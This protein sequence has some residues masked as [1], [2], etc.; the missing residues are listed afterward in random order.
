MNGPAEMP[1]VPTHLEAVQV[2]LTF[3]DLFARE[4][5]GLFRALCI[6]TRN[7]HEA[8]EIAQDAFVRV[9]ERWDRVGAMADPRGYL[10]LT[11]MNV[12]RS[13]Y[14]R[15]VL[16]AKRTLGLAPADDAMAAVDERDAASR[17]LAG[18]SSRQRAAV[19]LMDLLDLSSGEAAR[20][21]GI[22]PSTVRMHASRAHAALKGTMTHE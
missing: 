10:Y 11:A 19:V 8:E 18:L 7:R 6:V 4:K 20:M 21:L 1:S 16:A 12:F 22:R 13:R 5:E 9:L 15:S 17:A 2:G 14:R 3:E